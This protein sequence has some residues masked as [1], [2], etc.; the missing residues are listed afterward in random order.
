MKKPLFV[1]LIFLTSMILLSCTDDSPT[2]VVPDEVGSKREQIIYGS[3]HVYL[4]EDLDLFVGT[5]ITG[6]LYISGSDITDLS[7]LSN[8]KTIGNGLFLLDND[9]LTNLEGL[10]NITSI[11]EY[12]LIKDNDALTNY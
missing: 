6:G 9:A 3:V 2:E 10:N 5:I 12:L 8:L 7:P 1:F 4:Q 11:G